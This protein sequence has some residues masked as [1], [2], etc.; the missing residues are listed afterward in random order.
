M[1]VCILV[2]SENQYFVDCFS[3]YIMEHG[4]AGFEFAFFTEKEAAVSYLSSRVIDLIL[5]DEL[6]FHEYEISGKCVPICISNQS[7][8]SIYLFQFILYT[9]NF[10]TLISESL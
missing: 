2:C 10:S 9:S 5:A 3:S 8:L 4:K 1:K 6:F 7:I